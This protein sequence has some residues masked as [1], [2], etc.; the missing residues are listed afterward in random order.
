MERYSTYNRY[1][2][3]FCIF[4]F[5]MRFVCQ[6]SISHPF[7]PRSSAQHANADCFGY[8]GKVWEWVKVF[9]SFFIRL[10]CL[11][12]PWVIGLG[13]NTISFF[14]HCN[15]TFS[16]CPYAA[17]FFLFD[18]L[19]FC[20]HSNVILSRLAVEQWKL[21][22]IPKRWQLM[23]PLLLSL[24]FFMRV[25]QR[26]SE[27]YTAENDCLSIRWLNNFFINLKYLVMPNI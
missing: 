18:N 25:T 5:Y 7:P 9:A 3:A 16:G 17:N 13:G 8:R 19:L 2:C 14:C 27:R 24:P 15:F 11:H 4:L 6:I 23:V 26:D 1:K 21:I 12:H 20:K 22:Y 10:G